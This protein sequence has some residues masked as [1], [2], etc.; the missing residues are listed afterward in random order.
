MTDGRCRFEPRAKRE[1]VAGREYRL[2]LDT[3]G[4][5]SSDAPPGG[6]RAR[7]RAISADGHCSS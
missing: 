5:R 4:A 7:R 6:R 1:M 3:G 2:I